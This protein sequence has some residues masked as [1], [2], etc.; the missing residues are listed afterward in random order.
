MTLKKVVRLQLFAT[1]SYGYSINLNKVLMVAQSAKKIYRLDQ[2]QAQ[3]VNADRC[4]QSC[5]L[6]NCNSVCIVNCET[7]FERKEL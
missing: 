6:C 5:K 2:E 1:I 3:Y 7:V 4:M